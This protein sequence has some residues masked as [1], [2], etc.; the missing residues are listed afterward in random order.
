MK[1]V[2]IDVNI[3]VGRTQPFTLG[4]QSI[5]E[6]LYKENKYPTVLCL[7][8]NTKFDAKHPFS[9]ELIKKEIDTC[10][11]GKDFYQ[12]TIWVKNAAIDKIGEALKEK[13]YSAHLW[14]CGTDREKMYKAMASNKKYLK[15]FPEDFK[16]FVIDRDETSSAVDGISATKVRQAIKDDDKGAFVKMMPDGA[17][18]LFDGFKEEL[19]KINESKVNENIACSLENYVENDNLFD[20]D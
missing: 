3:M 5:L 13:G 19:S 4:H 2:N 7:I 12:D 17:Q 10:L 11:K 15:D 6:A 18:K 1:D 14:G 20:I 8:H 16:V 9:D